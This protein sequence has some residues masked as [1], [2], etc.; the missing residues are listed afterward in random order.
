MRELQ[1]MLNTVELVLLD[2]E[3]NL[4][5]RMAGDALYTSLKGTMALY[6]SNEGDF[7]DWPLSER[8][9]LIG[10][11]LGDTPLVSTDVHLAADVIADYGRLIGDSSFDDDRLG[12][13]RS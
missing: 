1:I 2:E 7:D 11:A 3:E 13:V 6:E 9:H 4:D 10:F 12:G 5:I 8:L